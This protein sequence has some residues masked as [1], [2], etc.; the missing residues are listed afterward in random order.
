MIASISLDIFSILSDITLNFDSNSTFLLL[1]VL[2]LE[3]I[4]MALFV[5]DISASIEAKAF[6][7]SNFSFCLRSI[8]DT[9]LS[10]LVVVSSISFCSSNIISS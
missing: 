7:F 5:A 3:Y 10:S 1:A 4:S 2:I 6:C 9:I 8:V